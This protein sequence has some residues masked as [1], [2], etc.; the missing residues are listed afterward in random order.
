[1]EVGGQR[2]SVIAIAS[3]VSRYLVTSRRTVKSGVGNGVNKFYWL[4]VKLEESPREVGPSEE[5]GDSGG[6]IG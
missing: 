2:F 6:K 1:L 3:L 4:L 5:G